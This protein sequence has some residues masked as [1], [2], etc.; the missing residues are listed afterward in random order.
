MSQCTCSKDKEATCI[1]HPTTRGLKEY[2]A[3]LEAENKA[4]RDKATVG[5]KDYQR[6]VVPEYGAV[7]GIDELA[8]LLEQEKGDAAV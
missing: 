3:E 7:D 1:V 6:W 5:V 4:L 8:V 2:I